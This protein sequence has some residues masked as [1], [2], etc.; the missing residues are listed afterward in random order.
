MPRTELTAKGTFYISPTGSDTTGDGTQGNPWKRAQYAWDRL[1][2]DYD[3]RGQQLDIVPL[4]GTYTDPFVARGPMV[5]QI[6]FMQQATMIGQSFADTTQVSIRGDKNNPGDVIFKPTS[7]P[8]FA[9]ENGASAYIEGVKFDMSDSAWE[10][11]TL[12]SACSHMGIG[13]VIFGPAPGKHEVQVGVGS[14]WWAF[15]DYII[16]HT[17][18]VNFSI[19]GSCSPGSYTLGLSGPNPALVPGLY[20]YGPYIQAGTQIASVNGYL[21][22]MTK[23]ATG[24]TGFSA[25]TFTNTAAALKH[26]SLDAYSVAHFCPNFNANM[27]VTVIGTPVYSDHFAYVSGA[28]L[29]LRE[30]PYAPGVV[31]KG[32]VSTPSSAYVDR[33]GYIFNTPYDNQVIFTP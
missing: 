12:S 16:D 11:T 2:R 7:G 28:D 27:E 3:L 15:D 30:G 5:G 8:C 4:P 10:S 9:A 32:T 23:P 19:N 24:Y 14:Y 31:F 20:I 6:S 1:L 17:G 29:V 18:S 22:T 26:F 33:N 25:F 21:V 13:R